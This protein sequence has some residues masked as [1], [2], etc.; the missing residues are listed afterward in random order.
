MPYP[1]S[2]SGIIHTGQLITFRVRKGT[3]VVSITRK[4]ETIFPRADKKLDVGDVVL[5]LADPFTEVALRSFL[6]GSIQQRT[7]AGHQG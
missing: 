1:L 6:E 7:G 5:I 2:Q 4:G 3:L